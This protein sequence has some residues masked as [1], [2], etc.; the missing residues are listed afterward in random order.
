LNPPAL[1]D[2]L[3][4]ISVVDYKTQGAR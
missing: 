4:S 1:Q 3:E 2:Y